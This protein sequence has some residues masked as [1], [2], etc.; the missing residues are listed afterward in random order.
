M[1]ESE[2]E[3]GGEPAGDVAGD[4]AEADP[5]EELRGT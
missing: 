2:R 1:C 3:Q 4:Y 5:D